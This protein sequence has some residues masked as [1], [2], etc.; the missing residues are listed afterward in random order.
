MQRAFFGQRKIDADAVA[1]EQAGRRRH[2]YGAQHAVGLRRQR[3]QLERRV[4]KQLPNTVRPWRVRVDKVSVDCMC[5][6]SSSG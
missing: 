4:A 6:L 5:A 3:E 1:R 2:L